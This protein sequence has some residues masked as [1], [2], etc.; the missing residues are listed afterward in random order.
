MQQ[1]E[2][3]LENFYEDCFG[4]SDGLQDQETEITAHKGTRNEGL[5]HNY[6]PNDRNFGDAQIEIINIL[7][8]SGNLS[9]NNRF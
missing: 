6:S 2:Q 7:S 5:T 9:I 4:Q 3:R 8:S 1:E